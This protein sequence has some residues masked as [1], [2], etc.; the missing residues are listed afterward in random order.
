[1][2]QWILV[3]M[4]G[5]QDDFLVRNYYAVKNSPM[6][7]HSMVTGQQLNPSSPYWEMP[8]IEVIAKL[9]IQNKKQTHSKRLRFR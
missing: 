4:S 1:M 6:K 9:L 7:I 3:A 8:N 2:E 5:L